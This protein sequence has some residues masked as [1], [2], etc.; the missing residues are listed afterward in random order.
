MIVGGQTVFLQ[1]N[2]WGNGVPPCSPSTT[3]LLSLYREQHYNIVIFK[4]NFL[5]YLEFFLSFN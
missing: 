2:I 3:P 4:I 5:Q 1:Q